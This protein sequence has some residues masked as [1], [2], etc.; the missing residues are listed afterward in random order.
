MAFRVRNV[1][2]TFE[3]RATVDIFTGPNEETEAE[4]KLTKEIFATV[5]ETKDDLGEVFGEVQL[6]EK[7]V[8]H[9]MD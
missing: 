5:T 2:G 7:G 3:K 9:N 6:L 8:S 4:A 1:F